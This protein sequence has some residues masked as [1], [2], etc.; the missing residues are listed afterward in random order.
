MVLL[1]QLLADTLV[2]CLKE[3]MEATADG[4]VRLAGGISTGPGGSAGKNE[5]CANILDLLGYVFT[6][7]A[8]NPLACYVDDLQNEFYC[9]FK[10]SFG[11]AMVDCQPSSEPEAV[12]L[13]K[14]VKR[15]FDKTCLSWEGRLTAR[16][17]R[18][19]P[20]GAFR[21]S[22]KLFNAPLEEFDRVLKEAFHSKADLDADRM[23]AGDAERLSCELKMAALGISQGLVRVA[24]SCWECNADLKKR[25]ECSRCNVA[26]YC[27]RVCQVK[28][29]KSG[30][31]SACQH[32]KEKYEMWNDSFG[33]VDA[34]HV[35]G[36]LDGIQL[37]ASCDYELLSAMHIL[38]S[39]YAGAS[40]EHELWWP[41]MKAFYE[42]LGRIVRGEWWLYQKAP[43]VSEYKE[44]LVASGKARL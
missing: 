39:P 31:K 20:R 37:R 22:C 3:R 34:A 14:N 42:N 2:N 41:S 30:H 24:K 38:G 13:T 15:A 32:L 7:Q 26:L 29:W 43:S 23:N 35:S 25:N 44:F 36:M 19:H 4:T 8:L 12:L 11:H 18:G 1:T 21:R 17:F 40:C 28:A 16:F 9:D 33:A 5:P 10:E 27:G 6:S